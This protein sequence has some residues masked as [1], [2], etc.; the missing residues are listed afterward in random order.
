M[1]D[2]ILF[3]I[4]PNCNNMSILKLFSLASQLVICD[5]MWCDLWRDCIQQRV[6]NSFNMC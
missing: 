6:D 4:D 2:I 3:L 1:R 5:V